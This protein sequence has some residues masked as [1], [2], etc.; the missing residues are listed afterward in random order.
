MSSSSSRI[1]SVTPTSSG[2]LGDRLSARLVDWY[3]TGS[4]YRLRR[5]CRKTT[6]QVLGLAHVRLTQVRGQVAAQPVVRRVSD[7]VLPA[8]RVTGRVVVPPLRQLARLTVQVMRQAAARLHTAA[9]QAPQPAPRARH[10]TAATD[11]PAYDRR[12]STAPRPTRELAP[13]AAADPQTAPSTRTTGASPADSGP[14]SPRDSAPSAADRAKAQTATRKPGTRELRHDLTDRTKTQGTRE[15][16]PITPMPCPRPVREP[17]LLRCWSCLRRVIVSAPRRGGCYHCS[18]CSVLMT[19]VDPAVG[20]TC[21]FTQADERGV[22]LNR[23][24]NE[25]EVSE[26]GW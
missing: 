17:S 26:R 12:E 5:W 16:A 22:R 18:G 6:T 25:T 23:E 14:A 3:D 8:L 4:G 24:A 20:M 11:V 2:H 21:S 13:L 7:T 19:V 9:P 1:L 15:L 10:P